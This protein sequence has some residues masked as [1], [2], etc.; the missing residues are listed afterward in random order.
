LTLTTIRAKLLASSMITSAAVAAAS[1]ASA[2]TAPSAAAATTAT[3]EAPPTAVQELVVTGSRIPSAN[4]TSVSPISAVSSTQ[5]K[6]QGA[7]DAVDVLGQLPQNGTS[8]TSLNNTPNPL[9]GS[10]GFTTVDLRNLGTAR[11]LVLIDGTRLM[12]GDPTLGGEAP[13]LDNIPTQLIDRVEVVTGGASAVYGSDAVAGVVNFIMKHN[14][15]GV[16]LDVQYGVDEHDNGNTLIP[17]LAAAATPV[18]GP[19][20][21]PTGSHWDGDT[22]NVSA[23]IGVNSPDSKGNVTAYMTY[24]HSNPVKQGARDYSACQLNVVDDV[25]SCTGSSNSNYFQDTVSGVI[26]GVSG[27]APNNMFIPRGS[28]P[29]TPPVKFNSNPYEYLSRGDERYNFGFF[30]H[31]Q[32]APW[33]EAY[34]DFSFMDDRSNIHIAPS[35]LFRQTYAVNCDNPFLSAQQVATICTAD[36]LGPTDTTQ[37]TI[38]RR[39]V[40]GGPRMY[41]YQHMSYR[42]VIGMRGDLGD[43]WHYD[44]YAQYGY[45]KYLFSVQNEVSINRASNALQ[46]VNTGT[47]AAP[48]YQCKSAITG[49]DTNCVPYDIFADGGV[50]TGALNYISALGTQQGD[51]QE[52]VV[53]GNLTG[54]LGKYGVKSPFANDGVGINIGAEYRREE[55]HL[56]ADEEFASGDL[57]GSGQ[58]ALPVNGAFD[59]KEIFTELRVP[60]AQDLPYI[61]DMSLE[62]GYRYSDYNLSGGVSAYKVA[63]EYSPTSDIRFRGSYQRAV[64]APNIQELFVPEGVTNGTQVPI[65]PCAP[66]GDAAHT[67]ATATLAQCMNTG[68]TAAQFGDGRDPAIGGSDR[69]PQCSSGQCGSAFGGNIHLKPE[70]SDTYSVGAVFTPRFFPGFTASI[71]YFN[72]DVKNAVSTVPESITFNAC[73]TQGQFCSLVVRR[74]DGALFN[75][76]NQLSSGGYVIGTNVNIGYLK[77]TGLDM[78]ASYHFDLGVLGLPDKGSISL[79]FNGTWTDEYINQPVPGGGSYDCAGLYG[80]TCFAVPD[81]KH[82]FRVTWNAPWNFA[83][84]LQWRFISSMTLDTNSSNPLLTN[85]SID[86]FDNRLGARNYIDLS[87]TWTVKPGVILRAGC[88]NVFDLDPPI[89]NGTLTGSGS[90]NT[91]PIYDLLGRTIFV[92]LNA[93]F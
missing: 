57:S 38:G 17:G 55:L 46:V 63:L 84:S 40:E 19:T 60:I 41:S 6:L 82:T 47:A 1:F 42:A 32:A 33:A 30:S 56:R 23:M 90:P 67:G 44:V 22:I 73:L 49:A 26:Y 81:W 85:G 88:N 76:D 24:R 75:S 50:T 39:N 92:G 37:L 4:L 8:A 87:G 20:A 61:K 53:S 80:P 69:I 16:Q 36:G 89:V 25:P 62:G 86:N 29:T 5:I 7:N 71:D 77:T 72:I 2:Q 51:T 93:S 10:G 11:T 74:A 78:S 52:Q 68:V 58:A 70:T 35:A 66:Q 48:N 15:E 83:V 18:I 31:Y 45:T 27:A 64:R 34:A 91:L 12:P 3:T 59:V 54:D 65:D 43:G 9:S 14:F 21:V 28:A 13:D 79:A